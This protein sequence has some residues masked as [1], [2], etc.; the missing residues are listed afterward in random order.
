MTAQPL[1][2]YALR[3]VLYSLALYVVY[4]ALLRNRAPHRMSRMYL[5]MVMLLPLV[6][7]LIHWQSVSGI[8]RPPEAILLPEVIVSGTMRS[9][10]GGSFD[11]VIWLYGCPA[12]LLLVLFCYR[13]LRLMMLLRRGN[14]F[15]ENGI[16]IY[17]NTG[18]GPGS[19]GR[20]IFFPGTE[21]DIVILRHELAHI[22]AGHR[23]DLLLAQ[24][25]RCVCWFNPVLWIA[26][27]ELKMIHE[28][29]ADE[30]AVGDNPQAYAR[31]LLN[32]VFGTTHFTVAHHFFHPSIKRRIMMLQTSRGSRSRTISMTAAALL[33]V[34]FSGTA[35]WAQT[36]TK[37]PRAKDSAAIMKQMNEPSI[38]P[39]QASVVVNKT[40]TGIIYKV[41]DQMPEFNDGDVN[42]FLTKTIHYP[43]SARAQGKAGRVVIQFVVRETGKV[44]D[45]QAVR[46]SG[47]AEI[48]AEGLRAVNAMP[49]WIP[50]KQNGK[51]VAVYFTLPITFQLDNDVAK[52]AAK[53]VNQAIPA[54]SPAPVK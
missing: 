53:P 3:I 47:N 42:E 23:Y 7:S 4:Y 22:R 15:I 36:V 40:S 9:V 45:I 13:Y 17:T 43:D 44:S 31:Q 26:G 24:L 8:M 1:G 10:L 5:W 11:L 29:E 49:D 48:D 12:G 54:Y 34:A 50:G 35:L 18:I 33:T 6:L 25:L 2:S 39:T 51:P 16:R 32:A 37:E 38:F 30:I 41:V 20:S 21:T 52:P 27:W 46:S 28:F 19:V 14:W